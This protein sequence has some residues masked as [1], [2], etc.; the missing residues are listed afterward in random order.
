MTRVVFTRWNAERLVNKVAETLSVA[1]P[2]YQEV[3]IQ[4][5]ANPLW[6]WD[7]DT[8]RRQSLLQ[9]GEREPGKPGVIV[10]A[11][12]RDIV[13]TGKL[14][15][16]IQRPVVVFQPNRIS[17]VIKWTAPYASV[18]LRGGVYGTYTNIRGQRVSVG[19]RPARN[20]IQAAFEARPPAQVFA[21]IWRSNP[22]ASR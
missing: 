7:W 9:G 1:G 2:I 12:K 20:W 13:D 18:V 19:R 4:Q 11:G 8:L 22:T 6:N 15:D 14:L 3:S 5:M 21:E 10:R 17:L 16:S